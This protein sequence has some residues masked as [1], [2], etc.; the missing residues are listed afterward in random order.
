MRAALS[1]PAEVL[2]RTGGQPV[3]SIVY[4]EATIAE[5]VRE[6]G[7]AITGGFPDGELLVWASSRAVSSS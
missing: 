6:L 2:Q 5:R 1:V 3:S 4:D 7:M